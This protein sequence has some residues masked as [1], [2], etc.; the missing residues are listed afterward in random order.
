MVIRNL[1]SA[2]ACGAALLFI[3]S[4]AA[5]ANPRQVLPG[6][7]HPSFDP[8][9]NTI[10]G[11]P[12]AP[13]FGDLYTITTGPA[14]GSQVFLAENPAVSPE[15]DDVVTF[16]GILETINPLATTPPTPR[17]VTES[18]IDLGNDTRRMSI[19]IAGAPDLF[20]AGFTNQ[21]G[22]PLTGGGILIGFNLPDTLDGGVVGPN[23]AW[24]GDEIIGLRMVFNNDPTDFVDLPLSFLNS[25]TDWNG[26]L[27]VVFGAGSAGA[28]TTSIETQFTYVIPEPA[29]LALLPLAGIFAMRR[30]RGH[31]ASR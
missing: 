29:S 9:Q 17:T 13:L 15:T 22:Q 19:T 14:L 23:L 25:T 20:P 28:L 11:G 10:E 8:G 12:D 30:R 4:P 6:T 3:A 7:L 27:G 18:D 1:I 24:S 5:E 2:A 26:Q 21:Q 31:N 16:D